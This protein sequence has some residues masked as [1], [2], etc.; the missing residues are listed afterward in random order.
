VADSIIDVIGN[1][2]AVRLSRLFH[3]FPKADVVA[4]LEFMNPGS[5]VMDRMVRHM[6]GKAMER[7][8]ISADAGVV[9]ASSGNTGGLVLG[10]DELGDSDPR[11]YY[12]AAR[13]RDRI[14]TIFPDSGLPY[15]SKY[16][17]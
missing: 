1:T 13:H 16:F 2:P 14:V 17:E 8:A 12:A 11:S 15:L 9:E 10:N 7:A 6:L 3:A 5:S 4:K